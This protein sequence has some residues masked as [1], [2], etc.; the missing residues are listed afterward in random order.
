MALDERKD[1]LKGWE[2]PGS[3][4]EIIFL[5]VPSFLH[6]AGSVCADVS[7]GAGK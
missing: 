2:E 5:Y 3:A 4:L 6:L 1:L 7:C